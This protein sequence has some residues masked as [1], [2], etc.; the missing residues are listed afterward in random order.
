MAASLEVRSE[1]G[2]LRHYLEGEPVHCGELLEIQQEGRWRLGRYERSGAKA[3]L[4]LSEQEVIFL[5]ASDLLRWPQP[6]LPR[7]RPQ[8]SDA[9]DNS[10]EYTR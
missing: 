5:S 6:T 3:G 1:V 9:D 10:D 2:G 8:R 4:F 7:Y